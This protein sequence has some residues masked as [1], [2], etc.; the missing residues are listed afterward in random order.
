MKK[1]ILS[2][3]AAVAL[4]GLGFAGAASAIVVFDATNTTASTAKTL[5]DATMLM[6][7]TA[8]TGH[9]MFVPYFTAQGSEATFINIVNT[10]TVN[11]KAV[12]VRFRGASNSD[13]LLDFTLFLSPSDV[14]SGM[15]SQDPDT[16]LAQISTPDHSCTFPEASA[17]PG[18]FKTDRLPTNLTTEATAALTREGYVEILNMA[19]V[20]KKATGI[21]QVADTFTA[22]KHVNGVPPC[23][24]LSN[25]LLSTD[26]IEAEQALGDYGLGNP[27]GGLMGSWLILNQADS[28]AFSGSDTAII[29]TDN[30][31][32]ATQVDPDGNQTIGTAA[33]NYIFA[34]QSPEALTDD[35]TLMTADPLLQGAT[36]LL[37]PLWWDLPDMSSPLTNGFPNLVKGEQTAPGDPITANDQANVLSYVLAK[38]NIMNEYVATAAG[39]PVPYATDWV[40]SQPTRRYLVTYD[41]AHDNMVRNNAAAGNAGAAGVRGYGPFYDG[42]T[43]RTSAVYG[44]MVCTMFGVSTW[45][46]EEGSTAPQVTTGFS[47][48]TTIPP[49]AYCG[50]VFTAQFGASSVLDAMVT[51]K[52]I[53]PY[54]QAGWAMLAPNKND[55]PMGLPVVGYAVTQF[56]NLSTGV[57]FGQTLPHRWVQS[58]G[59]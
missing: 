1:S 8:G 56:T 47:P 7:H 12:K 9:M 57:N 13:D 59:N 27:T 20:V 55:A 40:M 41:Y 24:L 11:G 36:P 6:Q 23:N 51:P 30:T 31:A 4:G 46:R 45:D 29:A 42:A 15:V 35:I 10:D 16:G 43:T 33:G 32:N 58:V 48:G 19:D 18:V 39:A 26:R 5:P 37:A 52:T 17:W 34:P 49:S 22:I 54:G 25:D 2:L 38:T 14:W 21:A 28:T 53:T 50:E 44:P 3:S